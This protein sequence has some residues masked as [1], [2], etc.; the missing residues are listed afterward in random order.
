LV[1]IC[2]DISSYYSIKH[3][4]K[5]G[6]IKEDKLIAFWDDLSIGDI[7]NCMDYKSRKEII[8]KIYY[9]EMGYDAHN[10]I[11][12]EFDEFYR[13]LE[14]EDNF[15]I[16]YVR[17]PKECCN[18]YYVVSLIENKNID[19]V[20]CL[21]KHN[22]NK[23]FYYA[24]LGEVLPEDM[25]KLLIEKVNLS[26]KYKKK[27]TKIWKSLVLENGLL[28]IKKH[29]RIKTVEESYYD[30]LILNRVT[31]NNTRMIC[32]VAEVIGK[33]TPYLKSW[34]IASRIKFLVDI[35]N[36]KINHICDRYMLNDIKKHN[37]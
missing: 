4:M 10:E 14:N 20:R 36:I 23:T 11:E 6:L 8:D 12:K 17:N 31:S 37:V 22:K 1:H 27:C 18:L 30:K 34:F 9:D 3:A 26:E 15:T 35:G 5:G 29:K 33:D 13:T 19:V 7:S 2:F 32:V 21:K 28:R 25:P 16:W 24:R